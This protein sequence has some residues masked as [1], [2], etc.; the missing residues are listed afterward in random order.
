MDQY[1]IIHAI[2]NAPVTEETIPVYL[3]VI[4]DNEI[5]WYEATTTLHASPEEAPWTRA[6]RALVLASDKPPVAR[7]PRRQSVHA[8]PQFVAD[9]TPVGYPP[10]DGPLKQQKKEE[11][12]VEFIIDKMIQERNQGREFG[13]NRT[14]DNDP[15]E[16]HFGS[17]SK[18]YKYAEDERFSATYPVTDGP[19]TDNAD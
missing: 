12:P 14:L 9:M 6:P 16:S 1:E 5:L 13:T 19:M 17:L 4:T 15:A 7:L 11:D 18:D 2:A 8:R 3:N 10:E